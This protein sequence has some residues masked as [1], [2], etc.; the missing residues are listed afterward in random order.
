M[1]KDHSKYYK[2]P[3]ENLRPPQENLKIEFATNKSKIILQYSVTVITEEYLCIVQ[4][5]LEH[6]GYTQSRPIQVNL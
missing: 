2:K 4:V 5:R 6:Y 1:F 3:K